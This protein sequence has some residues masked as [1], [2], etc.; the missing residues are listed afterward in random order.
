VLISPNDGDLWAET[1]KDLLGNPAHL[2]DLR[3]KGYARAETFSWT[4]TA[5]ETYTVYKD[6]AR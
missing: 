6:V 2:A 4:R 5:A 1:M 3:S